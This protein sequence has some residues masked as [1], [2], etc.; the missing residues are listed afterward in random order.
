MSATV[1]APSPAYRPLH[2]RRLAM[3]LVGLVAAEVALIASYRGHEAGFHW[4]TH[5]LVALTAAAVFNLV[6]L[7]VRRAPAPGQIVSVLAAHLFAMFPDFLFGAGIP[8]YRSMDVFLGH[9][10]AHDLPGGDTGWLII[11]LLALGA[12]AVALSAWL[13]SHS[14]DR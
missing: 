2:P 7:L 9:V 14:P 1:H 13:R 5:F 11:G 4:A 10:S 12:Y 6:W 8:H 3:Q